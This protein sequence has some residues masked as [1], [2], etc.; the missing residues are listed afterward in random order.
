MRIP[1]TIV[2]SGTPIEVPSKFSSKELSEPPFPLPSHVVHNGKRIKLPTHAVVD[3]VKEVV[4]P[5]A[6][7][8]R[9]EEILD[10]WQHWSGGF[11]AQPEDR[12][13]FRWRPRTKVLSV[14]FYAG[15]GST[16]IYPTDR[17]SYFMFN[18]HS[19]D[20]EILIGLLAA[21]DEECP[22][23]IQFG[24]PT[25]TVPRPA[26]EALFGAYPAFKREVLGR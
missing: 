25:K 8:Q 9:I 16:R 1:R 13:Y 19:P 4:I 17:E 6:T 20:G 22:W 10:R 3:G 24:D 7:L 15:D 11:E 5:Q 14:K 12:M 26:A 21:W 23:Q 18:L 2:Y